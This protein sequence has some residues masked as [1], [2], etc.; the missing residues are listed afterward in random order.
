LLNDDGVLIGDDYLVWPGVTQAATEFA[1]ENH[2]PMAS[3]PG[4]FL[5]SKNPEFF[6]S[7]IPSLRQSGPVHQ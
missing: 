6:K 2:L 7:L 3:H 5:L 1:K 4:K